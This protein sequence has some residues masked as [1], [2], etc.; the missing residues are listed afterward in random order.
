MKKPLIAAAIMLGLTGIAAAQTVVTVNGT[1]IDSKEIDNQVNILVKE[2]QNKIQDSP[3]LRKSITNRLVTRTLLIQAAKKQNLDK[4]PEYLN[5]LSQAEAEAKR[6]GDDKKPGFNEEWAFFK[7]NLL[8]QAYLANVVKNNPVKPEDVR[9]AYNDIAKYYSGTQEVQL[10]EILTRD[11]DT[12]NKAIAQLQAK[13]SFAAVAK[14]YTIDPAGRESGGIPKDY[15]AIKDLQENATL[16]YNAIKDLKKGQYT[17][18]PVQ[19]N[20]NIYAVFYTNDKRSIKL[21]TQKEMEPMLSRRMQ[22]ATMARALDELYK[23]ASI[24]Q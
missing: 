23:S 21:P 22:N 10:G 15:I 4:D 2:S 11:T 19:G 6:L 18:T 3:E 20:G 14:E 8:A 13:K 1:K 12:A 5:A 9:N 17:T 24:K 16:V 7:D